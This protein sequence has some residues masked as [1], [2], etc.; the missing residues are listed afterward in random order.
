MTQARVTGLNHLTLAVADLDRSV[1]FYRDVL[2]CDL[3]AV[4]ADG[5]YLEAGALWLC[6]SLD[7]R[8]AIPERTDYTHVA[9][10]VAAEAFEVLAARIIAHAPVW[11]TNASEGQSLYFLDPDNHRLELHVGTLTS[12]LDHYRSRPDSGV[13]VIGD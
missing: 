1:G 3:R 12:R 8:D 7:P 6:L 5:A 2:G 9:F 11:K 10:D 13:T 4:W